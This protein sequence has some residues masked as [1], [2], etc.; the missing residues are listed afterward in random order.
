MRNEIT[1]TENQLKMNAAEVSSERK[2]MTSM[3]DKTILSKL[4]RALKKFY[5]KDFL[6]IEYKVAE[7]ALTHKLAEYLQKS[8]PEYNVDCEYNKVGSGDPKRIFFLMD[9]D[10]DCPHNCNE[11]AAGKCVIFPDIIV[12]KRGT[13]ENI[14]AIEAKTSWSRHSQ[15]EDYKKL[16]ALRDSGEYHYQM[17]AAFRFEPTVEATLETL[18]IF[19]RESE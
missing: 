7:R 12:H 14:L 15:N 10:P 2:N 9:S 5:K 11:C 13:E 4:K 1:K 6:L 8:F 16:Q 19:Q 18:K 3:T 17:G